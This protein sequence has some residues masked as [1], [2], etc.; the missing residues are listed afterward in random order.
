MDGSG[1][2]GFVLESADEGQL[3]LKRCQRRQNRRE[4]EVGPIL[5]RSPLVHHRAMREIHK[6]HARFGR[7]RSLC[8]R[9]AGRNHCIQKRQAHGRA[10]PLQYSAPLQ[11]HL[12]NE[13][14]LFPPQSRAATFW[15]GRGL[16]STTLSIWKA[17]ES[18]MPKMIEDSR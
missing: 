2:R 9:G 15:S 17:S 16:S 7:R 18:T 3:S 8:N 1:D 11:M 13:H 14:R 4:V 6:Y 10:E 5:L 12:G